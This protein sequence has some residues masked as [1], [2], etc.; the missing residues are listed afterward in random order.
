MSKIKRCTF[1]VIALLIGS[2]SAWVAAELKREKLTGLTKIL[3]GQL[4]YAQQN[5]RDAEVALESFRVQTITLP[6]ECFI[7]TWL[8]FR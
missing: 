6:S 5:L 1:T 3:D 4:R 7:F 8:P 2:L